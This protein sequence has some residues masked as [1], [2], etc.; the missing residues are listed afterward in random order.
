MLRLGEFWAL[1]SA[2]SAG[3]AFMSIRF[4]YW[5][6]FYLLLLSTFSSTTSYAQS[7]PGASADGLGVG[8]QNGID[9]AGAEIYMMDLM[10]MQA[11]RAAKLHQQQE[12]PSEGVSK[13]D[14]KAPSSARK[15]YEKGVSALLKN[16]AAV[17]VDHLSK[18]VSIYPKFVAAYNSLGSAYMDQG[19]ID[20]ARD[21]FATATV[22]DDHLPNS[23]S[24]ERGEF[25]A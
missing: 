9:E 10:T 16:D 23:F 11:Q 22:L 18:A 25:R 14:L 6:A 19:A 12:Q 3:V 15:E 7:L 17:A 8:P 20:K 21:Q 24:A 13:L 1:A 2:G 5:L 4:S